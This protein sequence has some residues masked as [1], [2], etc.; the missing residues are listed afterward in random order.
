MIVLFITITLICSTLYLVFGLV[1]ST[2]KESTWQVDGQEN[3]EE[4]GMLVCGMAVKNYE[5]ISGYS[6]K[7]ENDIAYL[8]LKYTFKNPI[9][10][11]GDFRIL[12]KVDINKIK[13]VYIQ[14]NK[15]EDKMLVW[16]T[17]IN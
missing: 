2:A 9:H 13:K 4:S 11:N 12:I 10:Q 8:K 1:G 5:A 3:G 14:G 17:R 6:Y 15:S 7:I 16:E